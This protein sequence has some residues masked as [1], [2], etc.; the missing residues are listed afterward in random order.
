MSGK[1]PPPKAVPSGREPVSM[2]CLTGFSVRPLTIWPFSSSAVTETLDYAGICFKEKK[3]EEVA[4]LINLVVTDTDVRE[5]VISSQ[6]KR[7][8]DFDA[9]KT[10][11]KLILFIE[12]VKSL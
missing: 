3:Y 12:T 6:N 5:R 7:L 1:K 8:L 2:S 11:E 10:G 9:R 4:E